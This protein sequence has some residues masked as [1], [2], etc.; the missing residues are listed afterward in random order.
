MSLWTK[1]TFT[2]NSFEKQIVYFYYICN[3]RI[4]KVGWDLWGLFGL[5]SP[6][7]K[8]PGGLGCSGPCSGKF[9]PSASTWRW[10]QFLWAACLALQVRMVFLISNWPSPCWN[11]C[12]FPAIMCP[13]E[14]NLASFSQYPS[15]KQ[16]KK[17][18]D[19]QT[20]FPL[21]EK[22][23]LS[24]PLYLSYNVFQIMLCIKNVFFTVTAE[25][26]R[27]TCYT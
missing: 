10:P 21:T 7:K 13:C 14:K 11:L 2:R 1:F 9:C 12:L 17:K 6:H 3:H 25:I 5:I 24:K 8:G 16:L 22:N 18:E 20:L 19:L 4:T 15:I 23:Q 26:F 27:E